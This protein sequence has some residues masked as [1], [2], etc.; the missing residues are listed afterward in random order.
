MIPHDSA[1]TLAAGGI[2]AKSAKLP[3]EE[4]TT[5]VSPRAYSHPALP[6]DRVIVRLEPE[7][8]G[9]G[10]DAEMAAYGF[11]P[12][13][14]GA[15]LGKVRYRTLGFPAWGL[16]NAPKAGKV[17]LGVIEDV[18]KAK[19]MVAAKPGHAKEAFEKIA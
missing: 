17:A 9:E 10:T 6:P 12:P 19:R 16:V 13:E 8:V 3:A 18:R 2:V 4:R 14:V 15:E 5:A 1:Q 11:G 7:A